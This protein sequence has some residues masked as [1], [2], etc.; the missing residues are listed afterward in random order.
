VLSNKV[1]ITESI[2]LWIRENTKK[3]LFFDNLK[4]RVLKKSF[5]LP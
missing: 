1:L 5:F 3:E 2:P 4:M